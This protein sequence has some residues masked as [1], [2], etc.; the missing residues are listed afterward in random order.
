MVKLRFRKKDSGTHKTLKTTG[1][2]S[3]GNLKTTVK[4]TAGG[5]ATAAVGRR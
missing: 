1:T 2:N 5:A 4:A 3:T